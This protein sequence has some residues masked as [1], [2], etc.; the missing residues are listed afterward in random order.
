MFHTVSFYTLGCRLNQ[1]ETAVLSHR[2]GDC[3][4]EVVD[5]D[6]KAD[7]VVINTCTVTENGDADTRRVINRIRRRFP[8]TKIALVGCQAEVQG[9]SLLRSAQVDYVVGN[10]AKMDLPDIL[11]QN[12]TETPALLLP[13]IEPALFTIPTCESDP[14]HTRA[15]LK[16]QDGCNFFC[17]YC[18]IPYARGRS[19]SRD[20]DD[21]VRGA[22][23]L[24][25]AGHREIVLTG[26]NIGT[27]RHGDKTLSHVVEALEKLTGLERI[28][29]SSIEFTT[30]SDDL[31]E[32]LAAN[33]KLC[34]Y[35]HLPLQHG[36]DRILKAMNR[37]YTIAD[38]TAFVQKVVRRVPDVCIGTDVMVGFPG[39]GTSHFEQTLRV[40]EEL[41]L[42]YFHVFS[43]SDRSRNKSRTFPD[44][45]AKTDIQERSRILRELSNRKKA[46]FI[47]RFIGR[48]VLVLFEQEKNGWWSGVTDTFIRVQVRSEQALHNQLLAVELEKREGLTVIGKTL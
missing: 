22:E 35:L 9:E 40:V 7:L 13:G 43:Y 39:E 48:K 15:N 18:E 26:I 2:F 10:G 34:R 36:H 4:F 31:L 16:I 3:G 25:Q 27:Y 44:K 8:G 1:A 37:K 32:R 23:K 17:S 45:V 24:V 46:A 12:G 41:P 11:R 19:R 47:D 38:Y 28:R 20:F 29:I 30:L 33:G 14:H 5:F 21:L 6:R 42:A